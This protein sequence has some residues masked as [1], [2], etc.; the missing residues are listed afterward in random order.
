M[1]VAW[2][3]STIAIAAFAY[4]GTASSARADIGVGSWSSTGPMPQ[5][6][7]TGSATT[8]TDGRVLAVGGDAEHSAAD[9]YEPIAGTWLQAAKL[10][11]TAIEYGLAALPGGEALLFGGATCNEAP[12]LAEYQCAPIRSAYRLGADGLTWTPAAPMLEA[13]ARPTVARLD[14]GRVLVL[15]GFGPPCPSGWP[16]YGYSCEPLD[17]AEIY[18]P[19]GNRWLATA[20]MP[21]TAG[22]AAATVLSDS[23]VLVVGGDGGHEAL[24]YIPRENSW[25]T[26]GRTAGD[27]TGALLFALPDDRAITLGGDEPYAGFFGSLG[28]AAEALPPRCDPSSEILAAGTWS[29]SPAEPAGNEFC[30]HGAILAGGQILV[31]SVP[32]YTQPT[33]T[34]TSPFVFD[35][36]Q[37]CWSTTAPP[38]ARRVAATT[39]AL[40]DGRALVFGGYDPQ[41]PGGFSQSSAELYTPGS[42]TCMEEPGPPYPERP[43]PHRHSDMF[44][45]TLTT[46]HLAVANGRI[47]VPLHCPATAARHCVGYIELAVALAPK[48]ARHRSRT[49]TIGAARFAIRSGA[50]RNVDVPLRGHGRTLRRLLRPHG[51]TEILVTTSAHDDAGQAATGT[52]WTSLRERRP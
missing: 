3:L 20:T 5:G 44:G 6:W 7:G 39:A 43:G 17:T 15:G 49:L 22:G 37:R 27:R 45:V 33:P 13:R 50:T 52:V 23:T 40:P 21:H 11:D 48:G 1:R 9:L 24:R 16:P 32:V 19:A 14:D 30:P 2:T 29:A 41:S 12:N 25:M 10:P 8:L 26:A 36:K 51:Q 28:T 18:D 34:L 46:R 4:I 47:R 42:P 31:G 38:L 35:A